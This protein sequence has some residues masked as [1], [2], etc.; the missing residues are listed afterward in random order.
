MTLAQLPHEQGCSGCDRADIDKFKKRYKGNKYCSTCY[1]RLFK[2]RACPKCGEYARLPKNDDEAICNECIKKQPCIRCNQANK[3]IGT[4]TEY[5]G[6][7][8]SCSV[9]FRPIERCERCDTPSQKL[10]HISRFGDDLRVCPK[11]STRDYET[12][13]SCHKY[14]LLEQ[15]DTGAKICKKCRNNAKK[16]C[17]QCDVMIPAGCPDLC[18]NCYWHK[19]LW[20]K[21]RRNIKLFQS[22][23]LQ[24]QYEQYL[25]WLEDKVGA[26]KA[27]LYVNKHT[28]FFIKTEELWTDTI[29]TAEQ[30]LAVLRTSGLR[31]FELVTYWLD[32]VHH[33]KAALEDKDFCSQQDQIE[34]LILS[35]AQPSTA[36]DVVM[37][38]KGELDIKMKDGKTS[39]RSIKLAI[40]PAVALMHYVCASG[41]IL[42][43]LDHV[44]AYLIDF[45]GQAAALTGFINFLNKNFDT[46]IDYLAFKKSKNFNKKRKN[47]VEKEIIQLMDKPLYNKEDVL[48]WVKNGL[49]YFHNVSYVESLKVKFEMITE[50]DDGYAIL[51]QNH[52]YWLPKNILD[53]K[54][55]KR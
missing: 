19:N 15:D 47:K 42:P 49:R 41:A 38:Y 22:Q 40:K 12:C 51:L 52:S 25:L 24:T 14:R 1:A 53:S 31:K 34:K 27:A 10:T 4:L 48:N 20:E 45:S 23:H 5:G 18:D 2:K 46:S 6:V 8:K 55:S 39:I 54:S 7:C 26:N 13:A 44:K 43:N 37:S 50:T 11:C 32:E 3:P 36:Y 9:Y 17:K 28:H 21:A 29:P 33:I 16:K 30:L 35:L